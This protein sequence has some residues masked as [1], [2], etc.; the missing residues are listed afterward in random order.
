MAI[1][2][3]WSTKVVFVPQSYLTHVSGT[4]YQ[5]DTDLFRL[6]LKD[7]EDSEEG[8]V[9]PDTHRH[10][11]TVNLGGVT[12]ARTLEIINGYTVTFEDTGTPYRVRCVGAN[13]NISDVQ[14]LNNVSLIIGNAAGLIVT[15][16]GGSAPTVQQ[17]RQEMDT[18]STKLN[19]IT[20]TLATILKFVKR[21][22]AVA[23]GK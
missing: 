18:N 14:N 9:F 6:D 23:A 17:I 3:N 11:T 12:Y 10:N 13:H 1:S 4:L 19:A 7:V 5:L 8:M 2:V 15:A 22:F 16:G 20:S 21:T